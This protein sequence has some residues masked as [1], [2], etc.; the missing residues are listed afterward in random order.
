MTDSDRPT[1]G[2]GPS[3][4]D[5]AITG[6]HIPV[7]AGPV[8]ALLNPQ[9]GETVVDATLG[10]GGHARLLA[11]AIGPQGLLVGLDL[12][13]N[14]LTLARR[15]LA[16]VPCQVELHHANF[17]E[18]RKVMAW[19]GLEH[20]DVLLA[21]LGTSSNQLDDPARGFSFQQ[22]GP[23]DMRLDPHLAETAADLVNRLDERTLGDLFYH[24][25]QETAARRIAKR[26]CHERRNGRITSTA[27]LSRIVCSALGVDPTSRKSKIHPAT[28]TF[29]ALRMA[30]N[31]ETG[32]LN[33]LL[34]VAPDILASGGRFGVIAFHSVE[35]KA[36]KLDFRRRKS[37]RVYDILTK[38]PVVADD[39]ERRA[40][41][42]SRSAKLRVAVRL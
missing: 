33:A 36:I 11:E 30:V 17:R 19:L 31:D 10:L 14:N 42:R 32:S 7:L 23:L 39:N 6:G 5:S 29:L 9:P 41:P 37:E 26:I 35:D 20:V 25:A 24:N 28:R 2:N 4:T 18:I 27:H 12:D 3:S 34:D 38:K 16:D 40:N 13:P 15:R 8:C 1:T 22:D 21:D